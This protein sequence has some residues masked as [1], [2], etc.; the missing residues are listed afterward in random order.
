MDPDGFSSSLDL[1]KTVGAFCFDE[2]HSGA[3]SGD[4]EEILSSEGSEDAE[5]SPPCGAS[6]WLGV[7][8]F[9]SLTALP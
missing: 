1:M 2:E 6:L 8:D 4:P 5:T 3:S 9:L 7:E